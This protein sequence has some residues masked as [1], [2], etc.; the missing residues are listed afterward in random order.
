MTAQDAKVVWLNVVQVLHT[1]NHAK[2]NWDSLNE[3]IQ[4]PLLNPKRLEEA[5]KVTKFMKRLLSFYRPFKYKFC[6]I[7]NTKPNQRY[8]KTGCAL[9]HTLLQTPEGVRFLG[10]HKILRQIAE[11][12]AQLDR[13]RLPTVTTPLGKLS[14]H[15]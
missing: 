4:G 10:E 9:F 3:M 5:I 12:L 8:V 6:N 11:C 13:V 2:W 14:L 15:R 7:K 1:K